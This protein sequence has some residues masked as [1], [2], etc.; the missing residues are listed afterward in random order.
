ML[1]PSTARVD[2]DAT[3]RKCIG[4][5][6]RGG[7]GGLIV[8]NTMAYSATDPDELV[9]AYRSGVDVCGEH[10]IT[11]LTLA[12]EPGMRDVLEHRYIAAWGKIS[13]AVKE[14]AQVGVTYFLRSAPDCFGIN[15]DGS[16]R[17]PLMLAYATPIVR[18]SSFGDDALAAGGDDLVELGDEEQTPES[19]AAKLINLLEIA[20]LE[21]TSLSARPVT[22]VAEYDKLTKGYKK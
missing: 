10:N 14:V 1:N 2:D 21:A 19:F 20:K 16:P 12:L 15:L 9:R 13:P 22:T 8:V 6:R 5:A 3:I 17:H 4:F 11:A 18:V 7:A